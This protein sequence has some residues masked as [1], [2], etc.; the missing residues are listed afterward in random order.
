[1]PHSLKAI[2]RLSL[3]FLVTIFLAGPFAAQN[4]PAGNGPDMT[5]HLKWRNI[6]PANMVGRISDFEALESDFTQ[7]L[8]ASALPAACSNRSTPG[9]PGSRFSKDTARLRSATSLSF[10]R[11]PTS[12]GSG[13]ARNAPA[14]PSPGA[15]GSINRPTAAKPSPGWAW[16]RPTASPRSSP[17]RP[18]R[19]SSLSLRPATPGDTPAIGVCSKP[20][21]GGKTWDKLAGGLPNDGKTGAI[22]LVMD[23][24]NPDVLVRRFLAADPPPLAVRFRRAERRDLQDNRR[25]QNLGQADQGPARGRHRPDRPGH[26]PLQSE[27]P[28]GLRRAWVPTP[29]DDLRRRP[30]RR[31]RNRIPIIRT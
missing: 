23:P 29:P 31:P 12:S 28:D 11:T 17:I 19:T 1:M 30:E 25:R 27:G 3:L 26:L 5:K 18:I 6:G 16:R 7:V 24:T 9:R 10:R 21:D 13:R 20:T 8:V 22:D 15:T 2:L 14:T 4:A